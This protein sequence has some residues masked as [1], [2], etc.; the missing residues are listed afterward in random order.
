MYTMSQKCANLFIF[1]PP[2]TIFMLTCFI[3][4]SILNE[5][6]MLMMMMM[7]MMTKYFSRNIQEVMP[8]TSEKPK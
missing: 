6:N 4:V 5:L 8:K 7:M 2:Y 1:T 3:N